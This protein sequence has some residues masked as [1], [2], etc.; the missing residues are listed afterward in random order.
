MH[1]IWG[2]KLNADLSQDTEAKPPVQVQTC[3]RDK[4]R[5]MR[6]SRT[7]DAPTLTVESAAPL[8]AEGAVSVALKRLAKW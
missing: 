4:A 7:T 5:R 1:A 2:I 6:S 3:R 8:E